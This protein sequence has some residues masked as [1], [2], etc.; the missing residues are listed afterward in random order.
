MPVIASDRVNQYRR[1]MADA[2]LLDG[3]LLHISMDEDVHAEVKAEADATRKQAIAIRD[4]LTPA[5]LAIVLVI[6]PEGNDDDN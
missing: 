6:Q 2:D 1:L 5:E 4:T 3:C